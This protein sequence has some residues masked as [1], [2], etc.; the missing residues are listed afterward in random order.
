MNANL[1]VI[2]LENEVFWHT[3]NGL[4]RNKKN[5]TIFKKVE[6]ALRAAK[7]KYSK[8]LGK[9]LKSWKVSEL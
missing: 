8:E 3:R 7:K 6:Y 5:Q 4:D 2:T 9:T 1:S